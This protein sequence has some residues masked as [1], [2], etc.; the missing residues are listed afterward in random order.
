MPIHKASC[1][2]PLIL[3][4]IRDYAGANGQTYFEFVGFM[5]KWLIFP[6]IIGLLTV[7]ANSYFEYTADNSPLDFFYA[8][9]IMIWSILFIT[10]WEKDQ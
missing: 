7:A 4:S 5:Q 6:T 9:F 8:L 3:E 10:R 1:H 2:R